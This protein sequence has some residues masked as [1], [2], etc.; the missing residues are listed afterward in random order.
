MNHLASGQA[1]TLKIL[2]G[3][4][5]NVELLLNLN[6]NLRLP[7]AVILDLVVVV[8]FVGCNL[9]DDLVAVVVFV[10]GAG[11]LLLLPLRSSPQCAAA[12]IPTSGR[13][14]L[15]VLYSQPLQ[16]LTTICDT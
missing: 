6:L 3:A 12:L 15:V 10:G 11:F 14:R 9:P 16:S 8:V 5:V 1:F 13:H 4:V 7:D 2:F